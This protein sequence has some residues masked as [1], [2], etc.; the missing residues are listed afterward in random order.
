MADLYCKRYPIPQGNTIAKKTAP[1]LAARSQKQQRTETNATRADSGS[2]P[3]IAHHR[4]D[5]K[6]RLLPSHN[7]VFSSRTQPRIYLL[8]THHPSLKSTPYPPPSSPVPVPAPSSETPPL[9]SHTANRLH[10]DIPY[11]CS[12]PPSRRRTHTS[13]TSPSRSGYTSPS[14]GHRPRPCR[15]TRHTCT[16]R[17]RARGAGSKS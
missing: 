16:P 10:N 4:L 8:T 2:R 6:R 13:A 5:N 9:P 7:T 1:T 3:C 11:Y 14:A 15:R 12:R 17:A